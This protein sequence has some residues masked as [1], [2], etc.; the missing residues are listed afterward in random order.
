MVKLK[1]LTGQKFGRLTVLGRAANKGR[2]TM[3]ECLCDCGNVKNI[4]ADSLQCGKSRSCGCLKRDIS[5]NPAIKHGYAGS[6][7]YVAWVSMK[8]RCFNSNH[9]G[10]KDYGGRG[11]TVCD[12]W[13]D[14]GF[15]NFLKDM[16]NRPDGL[17][18]DRIDNDGNYEPSNCRW[19]TQEQQNI[20]KRPSR[21]RR[22]RRFNNYDIQLIRS[23]KI[24]ARTLAL[25]LGVDKTT[26]CDIRSGKSYADV[27]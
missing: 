14:D 26:I 15:I 8:Q 27:A 25:L 1:D 7:I 19:A 11:V 18:L 3:W 21:P 22:I 10:Y 6:A 23:I 2:R 12:R 5:E 20:N 16:G 4:V 13:A 9:P 17:T 24:N